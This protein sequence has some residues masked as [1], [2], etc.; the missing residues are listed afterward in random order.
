MNMTCSLHKISLISSKFAPVKSAKRLTQK[1]LDTQKSLY[2]NPDHQD[3]V[4]R[5]RDSLSKDDYF[6]LLFDENRKPFKV[7]D[8]EGAEEYYTPNQIMKRIHEHGFRDP[9]YYGTRSEFI[10]MR[11]KEEKEIRDEYRFKMPVLISSMENENTLVAHVLGGTLN[12]I[13]FI[14]VNLFGISVLLIPDSQLLSPHKKK[15]R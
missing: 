10:E 15:S 11:V 6:K 13:K 12:N 14:E 9:E 2:T 5:T 3:L 8:Y 7:E 4:H 1:Q